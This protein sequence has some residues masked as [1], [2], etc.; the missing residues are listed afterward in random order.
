MII[1]EKVSKEYFIPHVRKVTLF[2]KL[3]SLLKESNRMEKFYALK[4]ISFRVEDGEIF[5]IIG[6]NGSGKTTLLKIMG[7]LIPPTSGK[8]IID[9][10]VVPFLDLGIGFHPELTAKENIYLYGAIMRIP[11][12]QV[13]KGL[14]D[15][16][17][18]AE[19]ER[20][21]DMKLKNFSAGMA[22]RLAFSTMIRTE[23]DVIILDEV[24]AVGDIDFKKKCINELLKFQK[25]GKTIIITS[26]SMGDVMDLCDR[27]ML[28]KNGRIQLIGKPKD[29]VKEYAPD[30]K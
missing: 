7:D 9:K 30:E 27:A 8:V 3:I 25:M 4:D 22:M 10:K 15:I 29:V 16:L 6:K 14:K 1:V 2:E 12:E 24:F 21:A 20:F 26:H 13:K 28:L 17:R 5:G 23:F 19:V 18:F 11:Q